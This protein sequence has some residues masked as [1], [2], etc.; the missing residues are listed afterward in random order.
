MR[1]PA[2][3]TMPTTSRAAS[4]FHVKRSIGSRLTRPCCVSGRRPINL[5]A[6]STLDAIWSPPFRRFR[7]A[8]AAR[9]AGGQALARSRLRRRFPGPGPGH[10]ARRAATAPKSPSSKAIRAR[11]PSSARSP[12]KPEHLWTSAPSESKKPRL[13]L[14]LAAVDVITARALAPLPRFSSWRRRPFPPHT[15]GLFLKG[16]EAETEVDAAKERWAV[17]RRAAA[18][19]SRTPSGRIV[20]IRALQAKTP[21]ARTEGSTAMS[22]TRA[23]ATRT[24]GDR[25]PEGRRRQDHHRH[26]SRHGAGRR[27]ANG[28]DPRSRPAG[29]RLDR[30]RHC[31]RRRARDHL[32]RAD[33]RR[34]DRRGA[35]PTAV[36]N[37]C[38]V[39]ANADLVGLEVE[40]SRGQPALPSARCRGGADRRQQRAARRQAFNYVLIDCPPSLNLLT[41]N[42]MV[43][44]ACRAGAGAVRVLRAGRHLAAQ[45]NHRPDQ[46]D[47]QPGARDPGRGADHARCAHLAV[48]GGRR[49]SARLLRAKVYE[50]MIPRNVRVAEAPSHGKPILLYDYDCPGSQPTSSLRPR[51]SSASASIRAA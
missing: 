5:V 6:P 28:A 41:L 14:S 23:G 36:P 47:A 3:S 34:H 45:G 38:I 31:R 20:V 39:P 18:R 2:Q 17:R 30:P 13:K 21:E 48:E 49:R 35:L 19:A 8:L 33:R 22:A 29:Q 44:G 12:G 11:P 9:P 37:L 42:A 26:Q 51:S 24:L 27:S 1:R 16:R 50:T 40:L 4:M 7:P 25:Q 46:G 43:G 32:R 10:Y 15:V